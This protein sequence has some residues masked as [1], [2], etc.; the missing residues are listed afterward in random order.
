MKDWLAENQVISAHLEQ[1]DNR[2]RQDI[3]AQGF[4]ISS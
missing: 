3:I 4:T 1:I 2:Y